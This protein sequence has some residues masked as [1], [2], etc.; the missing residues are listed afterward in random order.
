[1]K[2]P[3]LIYLVALW[4]ALA[5]FA[6][7]SPLLIPFLGGGVSGGGGGGGA[8]YLL[9]ENFEATGSPGYDTSTWTET[10]TPDE[11]T[12][13]SGLS[14]QASEC[15]LLSPSATTVNTTSPTFTAQSTGY[16]YFLLRFSALPT[17]GTWTMSHIR[18]SAAYC[19]R[20]RVTATGEMSVRAG[21]APKSARPARCRLAPHTTS[22]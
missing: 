4:W 7:A 22:G 20:V 9:E 16:A 5:P 15:L 19:A 3:F 17:G 2:N 11:N 1:M 18:S 13:T 21:E 8:T 6:S 10:G 12:S 14:L